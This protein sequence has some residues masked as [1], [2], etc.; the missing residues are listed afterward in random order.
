MYCCLTAGESC[1]IHT[2]TF[3]GG[4]NGAGVGVCVCRY[5]HYRG[6]V[7]VVA[8]KDGSVGVG[9]LYYYVG[10]LFMHHGL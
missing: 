10:I 5:D 7:C 6:V 2:V 1:E 4:I 8:V 9:M 3:V